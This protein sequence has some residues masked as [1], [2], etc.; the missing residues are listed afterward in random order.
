MPFEIN[1]YPFIESDEF[2]QRW[3]KLRARLGALDTTLKPTRAILTTIFAGARLAAAHYT[4]WPWTESLTTSEPFAKRKTGQGQRRS[5]GRR[6]GLEPTTVFRRIITLRVWFDYLVDVG[7]IGKSAFTRDGSRFD[8]RIG[9]IRKPV[10]TPW[11]PNDR[12]WQT[13]IDLVST[14]SRRNRLMFLLTYEC[15]LR[16]A[17]LCSL[18]LADIDYAQRQVAIRATKSKSRYDRW[19]PIFR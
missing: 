1:R 7:A 5:F 9:L 17:E 14:E 19:L 15:A 18:S 10:N 13:I 3:V 4:R 16:R 12:D 2:G 6:V 8:R 11:L